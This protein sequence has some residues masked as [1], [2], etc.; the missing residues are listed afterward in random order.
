MATSR[1]IVRSLHRPQSGI[2]FPSHPSHICLEVEDREVTVSGL[3]SDPE[4]GLEEEV[5]VEYHQRFFSP[6]RCI[7]HS[8][9]RI[10]ASEEGTVAV[11]AAALET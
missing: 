1:S 4:L 3:E 5:K 7:N 9:R 10:R 8:F 11:E 6:C 2:R